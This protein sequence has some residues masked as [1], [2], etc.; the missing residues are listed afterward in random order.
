MHAAPRDEM[1]SKER[2]TAFAAGK[3]IDRIPCS[4]LMGETL[5]SLVGATMPQYHQSAKLMAEVEIVAYRTFG[6]DGAGVGPGFKG[7]AEAMGTVLYCP[8]DNIPFVQEPVLKNWDDFDRLTPSDPHKDGRLPV[9]L[10]ALAIMMEEIGN[11]VFVGSCV[12]GP[13]STAAMV[14]GTENLLKDLRRSPEMVHRLLQL[15]TESTL[16]YIDAVYELGCSVSI[17]DPVAS[18]TM[19]SVRQFQEF[20]KP[21]LTLLSD[22]IKAHSGS[23]PMLHIC[24]D[25]TPLWSDMADTGAATLSLDNIVDLAEAKKAVGHQVCLMGNVNPV[26]VIMKGTREQIEAGVRDCL[27]IACDSPKG[28][29]LASGCQIP[30]GTPQ[31]NITCFVDAART[32][33]RYPYDPERWK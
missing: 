20:A 15:V 16:R 4:P 31:E 2:M 12:G 28:Y 5:C 18:G 26:D 25:S 22:R 23:G 8:E 7:L 1:T 13:L 33:G 3:E 29:I 10:E 27:R 14:R 30:L 24:G 9:Y 11:D 17:A 19:I 6:H 21:Y 32:Y